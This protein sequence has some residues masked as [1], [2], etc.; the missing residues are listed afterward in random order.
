MKRYLLIPVLF[1][2]LLPACAPA[3]KVTSDYD[4][5]ADFA[6]YKTYSFSP[7]SSELQV[8]D[9]NKRRILTEIENQMAVKGFSKA[10]T[11]DIIVDVRISAQERKEATATTTGNGYGM[12]GGYRYGG[13]FQTTSVNV[14]TYIDGTLIISFIDASKKELVWQGT[15]VKELDTDATAEKRE[16]NITEAIKGILA[17]YPPGA[18]KK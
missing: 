11:G 7:Q 3:L 5:T 9:L 10:E 1:V 8:N 18:N 2:A 12:Y 6:K 14:Q 17:K 15:G 16:K 4:R 13:G